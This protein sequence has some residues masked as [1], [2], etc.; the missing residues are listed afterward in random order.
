MNTW[1]EIRQRKWKNAKAM[2]EAHISVYEERHKLKS[3]E[4]RNEIKRKL[5]DKGSIKKSTNEL[6]AE[7]LLYIGRK[8]S[9]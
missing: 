6:S 1:E 9:D 8:V 4:Y 7:Q 5:I 3:G 2:F